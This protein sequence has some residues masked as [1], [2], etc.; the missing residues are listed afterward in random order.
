M[1]EIYASL[2]VLVSA[3]R[4][5]GL[6][7]TLLEAMASARAILATSVGEVPTLIHNEQTGLLVPPNNV[8][9]LATALHTLLTDPALR[10]QLGTNARH[11]VETSFSARQMTAHYSHIYTSV[12]AAAQ[13]KRVAKQ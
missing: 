4:Q 8:D 12:L 10:Q 2:D 6:P 3:S 7:I 11:L 9:A 5:E 1:P 13:R